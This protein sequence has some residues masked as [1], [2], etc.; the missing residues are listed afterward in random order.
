MEQLRAATSAGAAPHDPAPPTTFSLASTAPV[1][2]AVAAYRRA[3]PVQAGSESGATSSALRYAS[4]AC[5]YSWMACAARPIRLRRGIRGG[6][7]KNET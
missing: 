6:R 3:R 5:P 2:F 1:L 4:S 7:W